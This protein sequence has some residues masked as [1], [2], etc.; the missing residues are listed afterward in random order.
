M[1]VYGNKITTQRLNS[2][3]F[4]MNL[5]LNSKNTNDYQS[6]LTTQTTMNTNKNSYVNHV[7]YMKNR[8]IFNIVSS[9]IKNKEDKI[10]SLALT[11]KQN[12]KVKI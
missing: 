7:E 5:Q 6:L 11:L 10:K 12:Q 9:P 4:K 1:K 2:K 3:D 8:N